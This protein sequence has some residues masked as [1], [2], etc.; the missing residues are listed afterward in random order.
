[1]GSINADYGNKTVGSKVIYATG[2]NITPE[3]DVNYH[4]FIPNLKLEIILKRRRHLRHV[5]CD[6]DVTAVF[7]LLAVPVKTTL[8]SSAL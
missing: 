4:L 2:G 8:R 5:M 7:L 1:M 3:V 6:C